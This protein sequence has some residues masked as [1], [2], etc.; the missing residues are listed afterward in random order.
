MRCVSTA[1]LL[2]LQSGV[3]LYLAVNGRWNAIR[4]EIPRPIVLASRLFANLVEFV[5]PLVS[6]VRKSINEQR[7]LCVNRQGK[8]RLMSE[9]YTVMSH[10]W[11]ETMGW[12][13]PTGFGPVTLPLR[14][15]GMVLDQ[16]QRCI[17]KCD[18]E[19]LWLDQIAMPEVYEDMDEEEQAETERLRVDIINN[20]RAIYTNAEKVMVVDST[21]L[22]LNTSSCIDAA[23][24]FCLSFS[25]HRL[26]PF[27]ECRLAKRVL[28]KTEDDCFDLDSIIDYL[29]R[30]VLNNES[31]YY[32]MLGCL[33]P[34]RPTPTNSERLI[35]Y[36]DNRYAP[37]LGD[38]YLGCGNRHTN[39]KVDHARAL[40]PLLDL[41][42]EYEW[43]L[44]D[45]LR[46]IGKCFPDQRDILRRYCEYRNVEMPS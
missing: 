20:L 4:T 1:L 24:V 38:I 12:Q 11:G 14:K 9:G 31:R 22:R 5:K 36:G 18:T 39:V 27:T 23:V 10:V 7:A 30:T 32:P 43:T 44:V 35:F 6:L 3:A 15:Q 45:G 37:L 16:L 17:D 19:W 21:L 41:K 25:M 13:N 2:P 8:F 26:W 33:T 46:H 40:F 34:L 42:W 29:A 28:L